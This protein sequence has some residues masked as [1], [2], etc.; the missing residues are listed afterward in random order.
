MPRSIWSGA[1]SFGLVNVP[2]RMYS[3]V[4]EHQ[5]HFNYIHVKDGSRIG[6]EKICKE[7]GEPVPDSEI[8]KA[9][10]WEGEEYVVMADEDFDAASAHEQGKTIEIRDFVDYDEIDP[11][12]FERTYMLGPDEGAGR[13]YALLSKAMDESGLAAIAKYV[14]RDKQNLG[15][16]RVREGLMTLEKMY[17]ADEIRPLDPLRPDRRPRPSPR[18]ARRRTLR[19]PARRVHPSPRHARQ[20][21]SQGRD[22][23]SRGLGQGPTQAERGGVGSQPVGENA[24]IRGE[25]ARGV[26]QSPPRGTRTASGRPRTS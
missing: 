21:A 3:A 16:L 11:I 4:S 15:C 7:E 13:V 26:S 25:G 6:Y 10:N 2:V 20:G 18:G 19:P 1:I 17:F 8:A 5:L 22:A 9:F 23:R 24:N 14:M 12:Y